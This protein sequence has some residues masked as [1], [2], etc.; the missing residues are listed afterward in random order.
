MAIERFSI[1]ITKRMKRHQ[2][3]FYFDKIWKCGLMGRDEAYY[4][5]A[6]KLEIAVEDCHFSRMGGN[7]L[8]ASIHHCVAYLNIATEQRLTDYPF[9]EIF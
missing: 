4:W 5:L 3:H 8:R 6:A 1:R 2:A 7:N 9:Y